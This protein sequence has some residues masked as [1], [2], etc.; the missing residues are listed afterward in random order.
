MRFQKIINYLEKK[1]EE[2]D[3]LEKKKNDGAEIV[4]K[5]IVVPKKLS[6]NLSQSKI[7]D[8]MKKK[9]PK[10]KS[11]EKS[12]KLEDSLTKEQK[13]KELNKSKL[14]RSRSKIKYEHKDLEFFENE[15]VKLKK[16]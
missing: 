2:K 4:I 1:Q 14:K 5:E 9:S 16:E 13:G 7:E 3:I 8:F 15:S 12:G 11:S 10:E 6:S